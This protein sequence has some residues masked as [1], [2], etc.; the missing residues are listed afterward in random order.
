MTYDESSRTAARNTGRATVNSHDRTFTGKSN[1]ILGCRT[2]SDPRG[3]VL[4]LEW[5][6]F[7][8]GVSGFMVKSNLVRDA[9]R[10]YLAEPFVT[11]PK[12]STA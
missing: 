2:R 1:G 5:H 12:P 4:R 7:T 11:L 6:F 10:A 3:P 8:T 9:I